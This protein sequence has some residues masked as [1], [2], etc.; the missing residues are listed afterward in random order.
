[1][2]HVLPALCL[3]LA[4]CAAQ[5]SPQASSQTTTPPSAKASVTDHAALHAPATSTNP[6]VPYAKPGLDVSVVTLKPVSGEPGEWIAVPLTI[7]GGAL[8]RFDMALS[9]S[10]GL[11]VEDTQREVWCD[12]PCS[13]GPGGSIVETVRVR[14]DTPGR[15]YL[16][17]IVTA[18]EGARVQSVAVQVGEG[19]VVG[20]SQP[21]TVEKG[22]DGI[23]RI[24][25]PATETIN[26]R[27]VIRDPSE[28]PR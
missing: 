17:V 21:G 20:K 13:G 28:T 22:P 7:T 10:T 25:M 2:K 27:P 6:A 1:M 16:D 18:A 26:G 11:E 5:A 15:H 4:A 14:T 19:G 8:Y 12:G 23:A 9:S 24:L 3:I